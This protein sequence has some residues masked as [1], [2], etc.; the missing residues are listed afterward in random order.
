MA[1][2]SIIRGLSSKKNMSL[3]ELS[4]KIELSEHGLQRI[5]RSN[6]TKIE[7]LEKIAEVL[8]VDVTVFF[9]EK[10]TYV[11]M[12][13]FLNNPYIKMSIERF[14]KLSDKLSIL[15]DYYIFEVMMLWN[16]NQIPVYPIYYPGAPETLLNNESDIVLFGTI[17]KEMGEKPFSKM[18]E[19]LKE[20][21]SN[22]EYLLDGFYFSL[23]IRNSF[24]ISDYINDG[25]ITDSEMLK[26]WKKWNKIKMK[27]ERR[28]WKI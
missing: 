26:Y 9:E 22:C 17:N 25:L 12:S 28:I 18:P 4:S 20:L 11:Q 16:N 10:E 24:N 23:F 2:L 5:I 15:K 27:T 13:E 14:E 1:N 21:L 3:K 19:G 7:T 6:S 8:G